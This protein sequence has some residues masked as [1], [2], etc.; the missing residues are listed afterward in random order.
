MSTARS[1][2]SPVLPGVIRAWDPAAIPSFG[3]IDVGCSGGIDSFWDSF[4][5]ALHA[6]GYDP[7]EA[8]VAR[9]NASSPGPNVRYRAAFVGCEN[10]DSLFPPE[11]RRDQTLSRDGHSFPL[12]SA[13][14]WCE[15][16]SVDYEKEIYNLGAERAYSE[17]RVTLDTDPAV[18]SLPAADFLKVD[19]DGHDIEVLYGARKLL[20]SSILGV[21]TEAQFHGPSHPY[22]NTFANI[23]TYLRDLGF[24]LFDLETFHYTDATLPGEFVHPLP[25]QTHAGPVQWAD[26][27]YL[28]DLRLERYGR[29][30]PAFEQTRGRLLK[31][32]CLM[33]MFGFPDAAARL[34][35]RLAAESG[36][37]FYRECLDLLARRYRKARSHQELLDR[38]R[39]NPDAFF[40]RPPALHSLRSPAD[41]FRRRRS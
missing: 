30:Y 5:A 34:L 35:V 31:T 18:A 1:I 38:F 2:S 6:L 24:A 32:A 11:L 23:D 40:P 3:L 37:A 4:G 41:F 21:L 10:Y 17:E 27:L 28:R 33:E 13:A 16:F 15:S 25:A 9:L 36:E 8:E 7:L 26:A 20:E 29:M 22:S 12:T 19:T 14:A 39:S